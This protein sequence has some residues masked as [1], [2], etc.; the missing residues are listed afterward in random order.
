M[1]Y[2]NI[3]KDYRSPDLRSGGDDDE[4]EQVGDVNKIILHYVNDDNNCAQRAF[5]IWVNGVDGTEYSLKEDADIVKYAD[6]GSMMTI[7]MDLENDPRFAELAE[8][9]SSSLMAL[10]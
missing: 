6:D 7:T 10:R 2:S 1:P 9:K 3:T 4:E 8:A 5:Y